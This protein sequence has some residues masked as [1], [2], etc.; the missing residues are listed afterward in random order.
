MLE[1]KLDYIL[2]TNG[3]CL[4]PVQPSVGEKKLTSSVHWSLYFMLHS[5]V[6]HKL[7]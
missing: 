4:F 2:H 1:M 5:F 3:L 6:G 7:K